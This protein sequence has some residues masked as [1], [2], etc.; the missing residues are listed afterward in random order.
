MHNIVLAPVHINFKFHAS[1]HPVKWC[2]KFKVKEFPTVVTPQLETPPTKYQSA[3]LYWYK[4][5]DEEVEFIKVQ[6]T[7]VVDVQHVKDLINLI[8]A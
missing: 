5:A 7:W 3:H 1:L 2:M 4:N 8:L 6:E